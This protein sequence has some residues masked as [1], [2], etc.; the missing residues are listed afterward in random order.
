[1]AKHAT[2]TLVILLPDLRGGGVERLS[3]TLAREFIVAGHTVEFALKRVAG[4]L[5]PEIPEGATV[6]DLGAPRVRDLPLALTRYFRNTDADAVLA[7]MWPLTGIACLARRMSGRRIPL[8]VSEHSDLRKAQA[9]KPA[10]RL[11][12][13]HAGRRIYGSADGVV[14][15]SHGVAE[16]VAAC[17]GIAPARLTVIHNPIAASSNA[18]ASPEDEDIV[19]WWS[20]AR[21][22][23]IAIGALKPAKAYDL[24][25][26]AFA[27]LRLSTDARLL[28]LG[29]GP[30]RA[31]LEAQVAALGIERHVRMPGFHRSPSVFLRQADLFVMSSRWEGFG[32]VIVEALA[33]GVPVVSTDCMS[34]PSEILEGGHHGRLVPVDDAEAL[35]AAMAEWMARDHDRR[36][37]RLRAK[38]FAPSIAAARYLDLLFPDRA[39]H[40]MAHA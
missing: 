21:R 16:S 30:L 23:V 3:I 10:E 39:P 22:K 36:A 9:I 25:L 12:L 31:D 28:L 40:D 27:R 26:T 11:V 7:A 19:A 13:R 38:D 8:V 20:E 5:L 17:T 1:M 2:S 14:C 33:E 4:E 34:G 18:V 37:L 29:D 35:A 6:H 15:V 32:N 24:L